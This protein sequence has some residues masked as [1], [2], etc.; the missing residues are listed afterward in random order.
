[1]PPLCKTQ[2]NVRD[3]VRELR[4]V[5]A[6]DLVPNPRNWR[7]HPDE[8]QSALSAVLEEIGFAGAL[9]ARELGDGRLELIDGHLRAATLPEVEVPVLV[10]DLTSDEA[11]LLSAVYDP[12]GALA[13]TDAAL[14]AEIVAGV[15]THQP[16]IDALLESLL[17]AAPDA[18]PAENDDA[19]AIAPDTIDPS[20]ATQPPEPFPARRVRASAEL[21]ESFQLLVEC[22]DE[23]EQRTLYERLTAEGR[24]CRVL[25]L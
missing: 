8:Q 24:K 3:R 11:A 23:A 6:G 19:D 22:P 17:Q 13:E 2:P 15:E 18:S 10:V 5:R 9:L 14:L 12:I 20:R 25:T 4:R 21:R 7:T 16:E 1:M